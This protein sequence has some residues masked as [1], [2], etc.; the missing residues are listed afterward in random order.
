[1][2]NIQNNMAVVKTVCSLY[3]ASYSSFVC[4]YTVY[5]YCVQT[6]Q[7][8]HNIRN[9]YCLMSKYYIILFCSF[10]II[11]VYGVYPYCDLHCALVDPSHFIFV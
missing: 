1:M 11:C 6:I 2:Q 7:C 4:L 9:I 3:S 5:I 10:L 8:V